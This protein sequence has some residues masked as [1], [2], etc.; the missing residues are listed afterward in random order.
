MRRKH[1]ASLAITLALL[2]VVVRP[3]LAVAPWRV[4]LPDTAQIQGDRALLRD[5]A[6]QPVPA[7]AGALVLQAGAAPNTTIHI[8][9]QTI[10]RKLVTAGLSA[11]VSFR[12]A[13]TCCVAFAGRELNGD[14]L[15]SEVR[16]QLQALVPVPVPGAPASWFEFDYPSVRLSAS[17][18][19]QVSLNRKTP[20]EPGRNLVQVRMQSG[21]HQEVFGVSVV[22]HSFGETA[23]AVR[24]IDRNMPLAAAQF[25][26]QWQDLADLASG[27]SIGRQ[28]LAGASATRT[29]AA[30][31]LLRES[32][33]HETPLIMAG[34]PVELL[35]VRGLVAVTVRALAR[36]Q[37]C[38]HQTIP[39][40]NELTGRL[41]NAR[42]AGPGLVEWR[43]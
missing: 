27:T 1:L 29:V 3:V 22:L 26:W 30:G 36:Q 13:A 17:G 12:G 32:D 43:R 15:A 7:A 35:V 14:A 33:L 5:I 34:D 25:S 6:V 24:K 10:L 11:G 31:D 28:T 39:V 19:W 23:R 40:R 4:V 38:L 2:V 8:S 20:L 16:Q 18:S 37:G 21:S 9:R 42:V 41:V